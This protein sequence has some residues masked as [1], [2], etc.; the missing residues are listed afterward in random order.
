MYIY[1]TNSNNRN[2]CNP[3]LVKYICVK[4]VLCMLYMC[5]VYKC[6]IYVICYMLTYLWYYSF[7]Q[8]LIL[9]YL[10]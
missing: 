7:L 1:I 2:K 3:C 6:Y 10:I 4:N 5:K 9:S 8:V